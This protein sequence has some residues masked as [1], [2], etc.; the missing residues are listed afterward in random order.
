MSALRIYLIDFRKIPSTF[1]SDS[2]GLLMD[3][4]MEFLGMCSD[5]LRITYGFPWDSLQI[6]SEFQ[7]VRD[8][9]TQG[10]RDS[11]TQGLRDSGAQGHSI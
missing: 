6:P 1:P 3:L 5:F 2:L 11:G 9:G 7:R 10:F 8:S 4:L